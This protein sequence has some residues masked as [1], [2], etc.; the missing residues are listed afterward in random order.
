MH[1][2]NLHSVSP[3]PANKTKLLIRSSVLSMLFGTLL[4]KLQLAL[5]KYFPNTALVREDWVFSD[6]S[7]NRFKKKIKVRI[8][9]PP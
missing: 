9:K 2:D 6:S 3:N 7:L 8:S 1:S 4:I 5:M